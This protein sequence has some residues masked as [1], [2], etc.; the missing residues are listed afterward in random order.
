MI[1]RRM[2]LVSLT[3]CSLIGSVR[4]QDGRAQQEQQMREIVEQIQKDMTTIDKLLDQAAQQSR[5]SSSSSS[6]SSS[7]AGGAKDDALDKLLEESMSTSR[8][9]VE[10]IDK[11][12]EMSS[13]G[14]SSSGGGGSSKGEAQ[15]NRN[16]DG[17]QRAPDDRESSSP[18]NVQQG[19]RSDQNGS[20]PKSG[21]DPKGPNADPLSGEKERGKAGADSATE[22]LDK[23]AEAG[24]WGRLPPYLQFLF[25]KTGAPKLPSKY[26]RFREEFHKR[27]DS[28]TKK[29]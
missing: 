26:D 3:L 6:S 2:T 7:G 18:D 12:L 24:D 1:S 5:S 8:T 29:R 14:N 20:D 17:K 13:Q 4:T 27:A 28:D 23:A 19:E 11:L 9:V 16:M 15:D 22:R 21:K 25:K 10:R